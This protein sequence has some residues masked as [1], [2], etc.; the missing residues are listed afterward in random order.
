[1]GFGLI[2]CDMISGLL[3]TS[4]TQI[5][6]N[7]VHSDF[8]NHQ[9]GLRQGDP[10]SPLPF[11]LVMDILSRLI[12]KASEDGHLQ[13]LSSKHLRHRISLYADVT[14][15][16][17]RPDVADIRLVIDLLNLFGKVSV[18]HTNL[19]KAVWC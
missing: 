11:I 7:G 10:L 15:L 18:L 12:Q 9:C 17:L 13:L 5:M 14:V 2:W 4:S 1:M 6:V 16:F 8:I 3:A 19:Q